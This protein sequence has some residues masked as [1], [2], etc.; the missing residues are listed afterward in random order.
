MGDE[1]VALMRAPGPSGR[2]SSRCGRDGPSGCGFS[3]CTGSTATRRRRSGH[4]VRPHRAP[5]SSMAGG[6]SSSGP[7]GRGMEPASEGSKMPFRRAQRV[8]MLGFAIELV[9]READLERRTGWHMM[10]WGRRDPGRGV[11]FLCLTF[12]S[13]CANKAAV[14]GNL[15][16][17]DAARWKEDQDPREPRSL[18]RPRWGKTRSTPLPPDRIYSTK[19]PGATSKQCKAGRICAR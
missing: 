11:V 8:S 7:L 5:A 14:A 15:G 1:I 12:D 17:S 4:A 9:N 18:L 10:L 16:P 19:P 3:R 6:A 13:A 2:V